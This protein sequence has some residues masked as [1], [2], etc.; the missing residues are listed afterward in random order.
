MEKSQL[1]KEQRDIKKLQEQNLENIKALEEEVK[2]QQ[3]VARDARD[4]GNK[5][6]AEILDKEIKKL[7]AQIKEMKAYNSQL[8]SIS[9]RLAV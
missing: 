7:N 1:A 9:S 8:A 3:V 6:E 2:K 5:R 4:N